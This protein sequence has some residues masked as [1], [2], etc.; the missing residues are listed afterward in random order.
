MHV[1]ANELYAELFGYADV[2]ELGSIPL[3]DLIAAQKQQEFK[4]ALKRY[5]AHP[6]AQT[7][8]D[9]TGTRAD[10][11]AFAG[12]LVLS[13]ASFEGEPCMQV[14]VRAAPA[15]A[16]APAAAGAG[17]LA[18]LASTLSATAGG[19]LLLIAVDGFNQ[20]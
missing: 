14:L 1:H 19:Q 6:E 12:Q 11:T 7:A 3:V 10:G 15:G 16:A 13:T 5:R 20:H 8:I 9:F 17:G 18:V 4:D 2:E